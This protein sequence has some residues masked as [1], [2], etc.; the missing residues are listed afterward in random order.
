MSKIGF[1]SVFSIV[2]GSQIGSSVFMSPANLAPYGIFSIWGWLISSLG[3]V[4][5]SLIF[6]YL[7]SRFPKTGGPHVYVNQA[8][9]EKLSFL[10]GWTYWIISW[11]SSTAVIVTAIGY[12]T[13]FINIHDKYD[14]LFLEII[15][16]LAIVWINLRGLKTAGIVGFILTLLK[17]IPLILLPIF[18]FQSFDINNFIISQEIS[19]LPTSK[20]LVKV[21]ALTMWGFIGLETAT[22]P[23][24]SVLNPKV[25]IPKA[26]ILGTL[27]VAL[28][29]ISN[30]FAIMGLI[31]SSELAISKAP[32]VDASKILFGGNVHLIISAIAAIVCIGTLNAW[33]ITSSQIILGL[34]Q[35]GL[36]PK[37]FMH[38]NKAGA[39]DYAIFYSSI[40]IIPLLIFTAT[41]S[42]SKQVADFIDIAV[43]SF[44]F[45]YLIC[46]ISAAKFIFKERKYY[47]LPVLSLSIIFCC[48][49][50]FE[51]SFHI[52]LIASL[53]SLSGIP[54]YLFLKRNKK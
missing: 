6:A 21:T 54:F 10:T 14:Y 37:I 33:V 25:T 47:I 4:S 39:V 27:C 9:G 30:C 17:F 51:T 3:A 16:L 45:V 11:V 35:D 19:Q 5:L 40:G 42:L 24:D 34:A 32:Y 23:A 18:A 48:W 28:V 53:F 8:F 22:A 13:P 1:W 52:L 46:C 36:M 2:L 49:T 44:L 12:L 15:L 50:I 7:C 31:P 29:Y 41:E 20:I 38:K 43:V 26:I